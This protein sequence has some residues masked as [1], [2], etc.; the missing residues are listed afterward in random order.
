MVTVAT[1]KL[2]L[3]GDVFRVGALNIGESFQATV[4][5]TGGNAL[6]AYIQPVGGCA[7]YQTLNNG[8]SFTFTA[9]SSTV[10][11]FRVISSSQGLIPYSVSV[12][13]R[14]TTTLYTDLA[15]S[16]NHY[17]K[18]FYYNLTQCINAIVESEDW[19]MFD[20]FNYFLPSQLPVSHV[21]HAPTSYPSA[22]NIS[23]NLPETGIYALVVQSSHSLITY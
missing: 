5:W 18:V 19:Q 11:S 22:A 10:H 4:T 12:T 23:I 7:T 1:L 9:T 20:F 3:P 17:K 16:Y 6:N 8:S 13:Y 21:D 14:G 15:V 2:D